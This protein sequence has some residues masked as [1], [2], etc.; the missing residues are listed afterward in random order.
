MCFS[1][2]RF[3][4]SIA[5]ESWNETLTIMKQSAYQPKKSK[6]GVTNPLNQDEKNTCIWKVIEGRKEL[7]N[8][9]VIEYRTV[10]SNTYECN[11]KKDGREFGYTYLNHSK[12]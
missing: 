4:D 11:S 9:F 12:K 8:T 7:E 10:L 2:F 3:A 5:P 6:D 1:N